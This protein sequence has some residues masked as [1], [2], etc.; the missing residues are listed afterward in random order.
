MSMRACSIGRITMPSRQQCVEDSKR[1]VPFGLFRY[2]P[3]SGPRPVR[4]FIP[5]PTVPRSCARGRRSGRSMRSR[6]AS[7]QRGYR[8]ISTHPPGVR[9]CDLPRNVCA[10]R[11]GL[12]ATR[13]LR[14]TAQAANAANPKPQTAE[15]APP[16]QRKRTSPAAKALVSTPTAT[17]RAVDAE[18]PDTR[19]VRLCRCLC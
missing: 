3:L 16:A 18:L 10:V 8:S 5:A 1:D 15:K 6:S 13:L 9:T 11:D 2:V 4:A 19:K 12:D 14:P 7:A 17:A